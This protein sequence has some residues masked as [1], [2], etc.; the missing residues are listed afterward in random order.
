MYS[1]FSIHTLTLAFVQVSSS[2]A[3]YPFDG[4]SVAFDSS[5]STNYLG[6]CF[7]ELN[8]DGLPDMVLA[9]QTDSNTWVYLNTGSS[10]AP[11]WT[12]SSK[13]VTSRT[14]LNILVPSYITTTTNDVFVGTLTSRCC[15]QSPT[16]GD[17]DGD[18][19]LDLL[20]GNS[21]SDFQYFENTGSSSSPSF[22]ERYAF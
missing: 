20:V 13:S 2:D 18:G 5:G 11:A 16:L 21:A 22:T 7:G 6:I 14:P 1:I 17:I 15:L 19:D 10:G 9:D 8:G 3:D 4:L 12:L